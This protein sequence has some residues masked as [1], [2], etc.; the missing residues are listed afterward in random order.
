[1]NLKEQVTTIL[2]AQPLGESDRSGRQP[3]TR[4]VK[5]DLSRRRKGKKQVKFYSTK[6]IQK[7]DFF[8]V[9]ETEHPVFY[10]FESPQKG[11]IQKQSSDPEK[12]ERNK[13]RNAYRSRKKLIDL[14]MTNFS[15][16]DK[17]L[18]LT[19]D[20][21]QVFDIRDI[22]ESNIRFTL[23]IRRLRH[24]IPY[25]KYLAV[26]EFQDRNGRGA[27]HYHMLCN[28][29]Y[30]D[31]RKLKKLW[32]HGDIHIRRPKSQKQVV[33]YL[34]KYFD[35][36]IHD[37]RFSGR[38]SFMYSKNLKRPKEIKG[39]VAEQLAKKIKEKLPQIGKIQ[40]Y[41]SDYHGKVRKTL[42]TRSKRPARKD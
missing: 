40:E 18:T 29:P 15:K 6:V 36:N 2:G 41:K 38:R 11:G 28:I 14:A 37:L 16:G 1:M 21:H 8:E 30:M 23:F 33:F 39:P 32:S 20:D 35:K 3:N 5:S 9:I 4:L 27:V 7:G 24:R 25:L 10:D 12:K 26:I 17:F 13:K 31:W 42:Y 19:Y 34:P 22:K